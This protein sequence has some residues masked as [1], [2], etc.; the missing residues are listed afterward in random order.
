MPRQNRVTPWG[1]LVATPARGLFMGNRGRLHDAAGQLTGR[2]HTTRAWLICL[3]EFNG[4]RRTLMAPGRYTELF[5]LDE[6]TALAAGHRPCFE[7]RRAEHMAFK[8]A[9][10]AGNGRLPGA[11][12][13]RAVSIA[14]IDDVLHAERMARRADPGAHPM[15]VDALPDGTILLDTTMLLDPE[16]GAAVPA[17]WLVWGD[18]LWRWTPLGYAQPRPR[19]RGVRRPVLT[20]P[21]VV[22]T[23]AAGWRPAVH[24]SAGSAD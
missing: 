9:W 24:P 22:A 3:L 5:F 2:S 1:D 12:A 20:P 7:C 8:A 17:A 11:A 21:S 19:P 6:P 4:R 13:G 15:D 10:L 18:H 23:L 14:A 16:D